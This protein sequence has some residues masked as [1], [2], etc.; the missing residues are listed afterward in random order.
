M[1]RITVAMFICIYVLSMSLYAQNYDESKVG[2]YPLP[3]IFT[4]ANEEI[5]GDTYVQKMMELTISARDEMD[6]D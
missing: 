6:E 3:D 1:K 5:D 4:F 2:N